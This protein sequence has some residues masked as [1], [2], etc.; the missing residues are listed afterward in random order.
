MSEKDPSASARRFSLVAR[1]PDRPS[2]DF[3][4]AILVG[5]EPGVTRDGKQLTI[6][7]VVSHRMVSALHASITPD[8][9]GVLVEDLK[10]TNGTYVNDQRITKPT[11]ARHGDEVRFDTV[12]FT[13]ADRKPPAPREQ[14]KAAAPEGAGTQVRDVDAE[15]GGKKGGT[16]VLE[17]NRNLPLGWRGPPGTVA[18]ADLPREQY[19]KIEDQVRALEKKTT[20]PTL[21]ILSGLSAN[22]G[23]SLQTDAPWNFWN[24]GSDP[25]RHELNI[26]IND[27]SVSGLHA[28]IVFRDGKWK[29]IDMNATNPLRVNGE[30]RNPAYLKSRDHILLGRVSCLFLLP[31]GISS[32]GRAGGLPGFLKRWRWAVG[33]VILVLVVC[34]ALVTVLR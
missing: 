27:E 4:A 9:Q 24:L 10:S 2:I 29:I 14:A 15:E 17:K 31:P 6:D 18:V 30:R 13:V 23:I 11:R 3:D 7:L 33:V 16:Q 34:V 19:S 21:W 20:V 26:V 22:T 32:N 25:V 12:I 8:E 28:K 5:R 1:E